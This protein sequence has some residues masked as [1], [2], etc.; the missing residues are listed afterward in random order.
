MRLEFRKALNSWRN[1]VID[2]IEEYPNEEEGC[3]VSTSVAPLSTPSK[4]TVSVD[5]QAS[6]DSK[7]KVQMVTTNVQHRGSEVNDAQS[8]GPIEPVK[9]KPSTYKPPKKISCWN[10]YKI[11]FEQKYQYDELTKNYYC[12]NN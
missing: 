8:Y 7:P 3:G 12:D 2:E 6:A 1:D 9:I 11:G 10:C 4:T 5:I